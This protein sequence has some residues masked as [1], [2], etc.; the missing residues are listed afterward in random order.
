MKII[1]INGLLAATMILASQFMYVLPIHIGAFFITILAVI[2][3]DVY[4]L[5]WSLGKVE[6]IPKKIL[7]GLHR[8]VSAGL[9]V[10]ITTG[11]IMAWPVKDYLISSPAFITK[12]IFVSALVINAFFIQS[13]FSIAATSSFSSLPKKTQRGLVISGI[14]SALGWTGAFV[15]AQFIGL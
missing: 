5:M 15:A 3:A 14:V 10:L 13:H 4:G 6:T 11:A 9:V 7:H 2:T 12:M 8:F 1:F